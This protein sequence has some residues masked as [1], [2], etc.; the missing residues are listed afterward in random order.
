MRSEAGLPKLDKASPEA[1]ERQGGNRNMALPTP[2]SGLPASRAMRQGYPRVRRARGS[3]KGGRGRGWREV[4]NCPRQGCVI[5]PSHVEVSTRRGTTG[6]LGMPLPQSRL[7]SAAPGR[8]WGPTGPMFG[9]GLHGTSALDLMQP[10]QPLRVSQMR[11]WLREANEP[12]AT[13]PGSSGLGTQFWM[14]PKPT[15]LSRTRDGWVWGWHSGGWEQ[16][17]RKSRDSES[18]FVPGIMVRREMRNV[19]GRIISI[20]PDRHL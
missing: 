3:S 8:H 20:S 10:E 16:C 12:K 6:A 19:E 1:R 4:R 5:F 7:L 15:F 2:W 9:A 18:V 14:T 11:S 17:I 13:E